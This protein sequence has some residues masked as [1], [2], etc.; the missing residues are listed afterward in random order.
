M[1]PYLFVVLLPGLLAGVTGCSL[2]YG[3]A[4]DTEDSVPEM[5]FSNADLKTYRDGSCAAELKA[6]ELEQY[7]TDGMIYAHTVSF[8][9][10]DEDG[11]LQ[12]DGSC[13]FISIDQKKEQYSLFGTIK[14]YNYPQETGITAGNLR[15]DGKSEQL[16]SGNKDSI[17][18]QKNEIS[19]TGTGF[20]ASGV[21]GA[22]MFSGSVKGI[23]TSKDENDKTK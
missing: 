12:T 2:D 22:F 18:L 5:F 10:W 14:I 23:I 15:W 8:T 17:E 11:V 6:R 9:T 4:I 3:T 1:K 13:R 19:L 20:S 7:R 21:G 16:V